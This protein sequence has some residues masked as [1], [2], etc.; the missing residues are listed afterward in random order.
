MVVKLDEKKR[1]N[2]TF[3]TFLNCLPSIL[4]LGLTVFESQL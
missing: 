4:S 2:L 3:N 1:N